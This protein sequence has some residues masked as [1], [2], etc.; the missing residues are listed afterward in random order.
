MKR[1]AVP[2]YR[3]LFDYAGYKRYE[4][5]K[6]KTY[7]RNEA[8]V[9]FLE[10]FRKKQSGTLLLD[11]DCSVRMY[12]EINM[13]I[14]RGI[15]LG[16]YK[17]GDNL[18]EILEEAEKTVTT[19]YDKLRYSLRIATTNGVLSNYKTI[20]ET[21][22]REEA[23]GMFLD[24]FRK[25]KLNSS[26]GENT[27]DIVLEIAISPYSSDTRSLYLKFVEDEQ[28]LLTRFAELERITVENF[29]RS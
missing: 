29:V 24:L 28:G 4:E 21:E 12:V 22:D 19:S 6:L 20:F 23:L 7:D 9:Y 10:L 15:N 11:S 3:I 8:M 27:P 26:T 13:Y 25:K 2:Y 16:D 1:K 5:N 14:L 18:K 17:E